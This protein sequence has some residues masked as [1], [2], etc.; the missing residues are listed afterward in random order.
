MARGVGMRRSRVM[1][2][3]LA[4]VLTA[5][6]ACHGTAPTEGGNG[7]GSG[8]GPGTGGGGGSQADRFTYDAGSTAQWFVVT[9][10]IASYLLHESPLGAAPPQRSLRGTV[11]PRLLTDTVTLSDSIGGPPAGSDLVAPGSM[12]YDTAGAIWISVAGSHADG[13]LVAYSRAQLGQGGALAPVTV[14]H[15]LQTPAGLAFDST[16]ALW[17]VDA[18][19]DQ[20]VRY[21]PT[22]LAVGAP[23]TPAAV[24]SLAGIT[25]GGTT[26]TPSGIAIARGG[27]VWISAALT[28]RP[29]G[30]AGDSLPAFIAVEYS[31]GTLVSGATPAPAMTLF[32]PGLQS[33]GVGPGLALDAGG[34]LW[35]LNG[36][37]G[38]LTEFAAA[39]LVPGSNPTPAV[40]LTTPPLRAATDLAFD[41]RGILY[42]GGGASGALYGY[43]PSQ[44][45]ASGT[46]SPALSFAPATALAHFA[47]AR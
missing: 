1:R 38:T 47:V 16:G 9:G 43:T 27:A 22:Q 40:T 2:G 31:A 34:N 14:V 46:P 32:R 20:L 12:A 17:V 13:A 11:H 15:G 35:T 44:L 26:W 30:P 42:A 18:A 29:P 36:A 19:A 45:A 41:G 28:V 24:V 5:T 39:T 10:L 8:G 4:A 6:V 3:V 33:G 7:S 23:V 21:S 25:A 37:A